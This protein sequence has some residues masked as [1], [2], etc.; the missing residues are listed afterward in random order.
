MAH[1]RTL[2]NLLLLPRSQVL[3]KAVFLPV[4]RNLQKS[5]DNDLWLLLL[6]CV[7]KITG[8]HD[9]QA[10][11]KDTFSNHVLKCGYITFNNPS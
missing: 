8:Y 5:E 1:S 10:A 4:D 9:I 11:I 3:Q 6:C 2:G 7:N